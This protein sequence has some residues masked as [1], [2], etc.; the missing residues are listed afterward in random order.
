MTTR[1]QNPEL[2]PVLAVRAIS[3]SF[4]CKAGEPG[5]DKDTDD[6]FTEFEQD[7]DTKEPKEV[8]K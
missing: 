2:F 8:Y 4:T 3:G 7:K 6:I 5:H 1:Y